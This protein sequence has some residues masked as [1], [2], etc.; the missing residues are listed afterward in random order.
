MAWPPSGL[1]LERRLSSRWM[2][3]NG[4]NGNGSRR[5][6]R[7]GLWSQERDYQTTRLPGRD[8]EDQESTEEGRRE[9]LQAD[10]CG[11]ASAG[12]LD[13]SR[14]WILRFLASLDTRR[15][16]PTAQTSPARYPSCLIL[17]QVNQ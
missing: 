1:A 7:G 14:F 11:R 5:V 17:P 12:N 6:T 13:W 8:P 15:P 3:G 9:Q 16:S 10:G 2:D 4:N